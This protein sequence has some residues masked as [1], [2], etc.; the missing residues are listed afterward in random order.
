MKRGTGQNYMIR[1]L[2]ITI[3]ISLSCGFL[4]GCATHQARS[5]HISGFL[6]DYSQL[7]EG[8]GDEALLVYIKSGVDFKKYDKILLEPIK[9]YAQPQKS[10]WR[11][12]TDKETQAML[13]Y[14]DASIRKSLEDE[15][16]FVNKPGAGVLKIRIAITEAN[17]SNVP[18]DVVS[19]ILPVGIALSA[20]KGVATGKES[21]VGSAGVEMEV[22]DSQ[23]GERLGAFVDERIGY[24][25]TGRF[26]KF[27][28]WRAAKAAFDYWALRMNIRLA[29]LRHSDK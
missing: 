23:T 7:K 14:F 1:F 19:S 15:M 4:T 5:A 17:A 6:E 24:K 16:K 18:R 20:L 8:S 13:D 9:V 21:A 10:F 25:Y 12:A 11:D 29:E 22:L 2:V 3:L 26:D 28:Q 27:S